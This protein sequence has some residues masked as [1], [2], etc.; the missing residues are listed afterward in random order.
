MDNF[1]LT[2]NH[3]DCIVTMPIAKINIIVTALLW[4]FVPNSENF[5]NKIIL[6]FSV[7]ILQ[8]RTRARTSRFWR[9]ARRTTSPSWSSSR[10]SLPA[11]KRFLSNPSVYKFFCLFSSFT[12]CL[13]LLYFFRIFACNIFWL[14]FNLW[15]LLFFLSVCVFFVFS[16]LSNLFSA[17][18]CCML[19]F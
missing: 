16:V 11:I 19:L 15:P 6:F 2:F 8:K 7:T 4:Y 1:L 9:S 12:F 18:F 3:F 13:F 14:F 10:N 5:C 17:L